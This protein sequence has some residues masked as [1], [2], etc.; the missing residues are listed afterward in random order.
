M[1]QQILKDAMHIT[2]VM[3]KITLITF[4]FSYILIS[5]NTIK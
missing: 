3:E 4:I 5:T 2:N 1:H